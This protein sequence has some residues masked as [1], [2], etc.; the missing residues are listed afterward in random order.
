[1][2]QLQIA[3]PPVRPPCIVPPVSTNAGKLL[4]AL[5]QGFRATILNA[6]PELGVGALSQEIGRLKNKYGWGDII[7]SRRI[8]TKTGAT[9][10]E[11][12]MDAQ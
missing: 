5:Q 6:G 1:M 2:T 4:Q 8:Q 3:F 12:W 11:Y 7:Q 9:I 10:A